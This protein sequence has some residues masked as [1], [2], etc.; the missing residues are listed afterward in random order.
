MSSTPTRWSDPVGPFRSDQIHEGDHY[1][2]SEGH[3]IH[4]MTAGRR[5]GSAHTLGGAV[6]ASDPAVAQQVGIDVGISWNDGKNLR[7]PDIV[8][9]MDL[10]G[11]GWAKEAPPLAVEYADAGQDEAQL[12]QKIVE[13][14]EF[15]TRMLWVV[16]LTG[17][18]RVEV[19][20]PGVAMR[21]VPGDGELQA[22]GI[23]QNPVP[24]RALIDPNV[25]H[26]ATLR[27]LLARKGY[28][29]LEAVRAEG[30]HEGREEA[31]EQTRAAVQAQLTARGWTLT[32]SLA[33]RI[34]SCSELAMLLRWLTRAVTSD[35]PEAALD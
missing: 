15:G 32:P 33:A 14:L 35:S 27:N 16:R 28:A 6:L 10:Q 7:A 20:E 1:E 3:A 23:L 18:L 12:Q 26:E 8:V 31:V 30:Q 5:H 22:P 25:A 2:L 34:A 9:G 19:H 17:P 29:S 13:L 24:V 21:I 4:C 11:P